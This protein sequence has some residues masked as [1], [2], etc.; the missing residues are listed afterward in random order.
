MKLAILGATGRTGRHLL[1]LA[2]DAG[3]QVRAL[4]RRAEAL[5]PHPALTVIQGEL[6]SPAF[7]ET[8]EG[9]DAVLSA[10]GP[11]PQDV[12]VCSAAAQQA[13]AHP[14]KRYISVSGAG[15]DAPGDRKGLGARLV[16]FIVTHVTPAIAVD[17]R[18]ELTLLLQSQLDWT[19]VRPPR[20]VA[21][22]PGKK[23]VKVSLEQAPGNAIG[24][25]D[26]AAFCLAQA[27]SAQFSRRAPFVAW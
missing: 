23:P 13:I 19:L 4:A 12:Q 15:V 25:G 16:S 7:G 3:H 1:K 2:L 18:V 20:L 10:L 9:C 24:R 26:L 8:V 11:G 17:K 6:R 21:A 27:S 5:P 22:S 14:V